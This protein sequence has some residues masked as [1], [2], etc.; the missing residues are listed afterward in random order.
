MNRVDVQAQQ[1]TWERWIIHADMPQ[2]FH[3]QGVSFLVKSVN[4]AAA[5]AESWLEGY[6]LGGWYG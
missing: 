1:G 3:I 4:C 2:A 5:M 6:G